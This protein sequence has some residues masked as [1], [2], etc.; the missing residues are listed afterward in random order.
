MDLQEIHPLDAKLISTRMLEAA[1]ATALGTP[2][3]DD[4]DW[5]TE[6]FPWWVVMAGHSQQF[7]ALLQEC[8]VSVKVTRARNGNPEL[9]IQTEQRSYSVRVAGGRLRVG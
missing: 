5:S 8:V 2:G 7:A 1:L 9:V 3:T 4:V 6:G